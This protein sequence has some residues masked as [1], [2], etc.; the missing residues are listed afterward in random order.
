MMRGWESGGAP[1]NLRPEL[2]AL[3]RFGGR[4][5][6]RR[7]PCR[8]FPPPPWWTLWDFRNYAR[9][10][11]A[12]PGASDRSWFS[13]LRWLRARPAVESRP[14]IGGLPRHAE[15]FRLDC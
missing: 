6:R 10:R 7:L 1:L 14:H 5:V 2:A 9:E 11:R 3:R 15:P 8:N 4:L 12:T 13:R